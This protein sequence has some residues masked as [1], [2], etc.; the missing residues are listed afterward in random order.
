[1][2]VCC[3]SLNPSDPHSIF[4]ES[5]DEILRVWDSRSASRPVN[6]TSVS[7]GG[8][9]WRIKHHPSLSGVVL[10]ACICITVLL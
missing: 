6:K 4:T 2:V 5:V 10:V 8:G 7:L 9:V 1:M 3:I